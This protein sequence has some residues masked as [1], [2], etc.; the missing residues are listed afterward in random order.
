QKA[1]NWNP[2]IR[3]ILVLANKKDL[4]KNI[5]DTL[6]LLLDILNLSHVL[7]SRNY[8]FR[9]FTTSARTGEGLEEAFRWLAR[10]M[11]DQ[12]ELLPKTGHPVVSSYIQRT[13]GLSADKVAQIDMMPPREDITLISGFY[14]AIGSFVSKMFDGRISNVEIRGFSGKSYRLVNV[15]KDDFFCLL[16]VESGDKRTSVTI[17][18]IGNELL[19][20]VS[21]QQ[22]LHAPIE[23]SK[24]HSLI[25]PFYLNG[26]DQGSTLSTG[27]G[28]TFLTNGT[29]VKRYDSY[30]F[31]SLSVMDR[32]KSKKV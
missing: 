2:D 18:A 9:F 15:E 25:N 24:L 17:E 20:Y 30:F 10:K 19:D 23:K 31:T 13:E 12:E 11:T 16:L 28:R 1:I 21:R 26:E 3:D 7:S 8:N 6:N 14:S 27:H 4:I 22:K 29:K 5:G 32:M